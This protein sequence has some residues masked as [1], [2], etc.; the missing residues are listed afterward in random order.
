VANGTRSVKK[1]RIGEKEGD[2]ERREKRK[3]KESLLLDRPV[4]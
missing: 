2:K 3:E 4:L 1:R